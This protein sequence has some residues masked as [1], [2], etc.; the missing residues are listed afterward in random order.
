MAAAIAAALMLVFAP[1][2]LSSGAADDYC[3]SRGPAVSEE[4]DGTSSSPI[5][6]WPPGQQCRYETASGEVTTEDLGSVGGFAIM[7]AGG[8]L[9][10]FRRSR[11]TWSSLIVLGLAGL[12]SLNFGFQSTVMA[13]VLGGSVVLVATRSVIATATAVGMLVVGAIP[14][15]WNGTTLGWTVL[16]L[17][18]S[19]ADG[20]LDAA[21]KR[22]VR[23]FSGPQA[24]F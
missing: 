13:L 19:I 8:A 18:V 12:F 22:L 1:A 5:I 3:F 16:I 6:W 9:A 20:V 11:Y 14:Y 15:L 10:V 21:D 2:G 4:F 24:E 17:L 7:L 23:W